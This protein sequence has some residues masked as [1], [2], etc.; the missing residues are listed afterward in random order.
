LVQRV[1]LLLTP[2]EGVARQPEDGQCRRPL[3]GEDRPFGLSQLGRGL[4]SELVGQ[5]AA[6]GLEGPQGID[7][8]ALSSQGLHAHRHQAF[9]VGELGQRRFRGARG[10]RGAARRQQQS[11]A[12]LQHACPHLLQPTGLDA[13][14]VDV[15]DARVRPSPPEVESLSQQRRAGLR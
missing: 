1:E 7:L 14:R 4:Q 12:G 8:P 6:E 13:H 9:P 11:G 10:V 3:G 15:V 5:Q 2:D